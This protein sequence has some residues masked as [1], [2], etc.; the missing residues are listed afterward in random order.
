MYKVVT[1]E[2]KVGSERQG[3]GGRKREVGK[4][5]VRRRTGEHHERVVGRG[6]EGRGSEREVGRGRGRGR[7]RE[8]ERAARGRECGCAPLVNT[9][10]V[11]FS[12]PRARIASRRW[13]MDRSMAVTMV[14]YCQRCAGGEGAARGRG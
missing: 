11:L 3:E 4:V 12:T 2:R 8:R 14:L 7:E 5:R 9:T 1:R 10:S 13:P 6:S